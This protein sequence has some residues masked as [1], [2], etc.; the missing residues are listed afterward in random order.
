MAGRMAAFW[1]GSTRPTVSQLGWLNPR[2]RTATQAAARGVGDR[3]PGYQVVL[4]NNIAATVTPPA[5]P[6]SIRG[7]NHQEWDGPLLADEPEAG[8]GGLAAEPAGTEAAAECLDPR[9]YEDAPHC[10]VVPMLAGCVAGG[11]P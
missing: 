6:A 5:L 2:G 1:R 9:T 3:K 8:A 4:R 10:N 11:S 7:A